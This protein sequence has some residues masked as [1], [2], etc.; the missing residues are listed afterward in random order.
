MALRSD[1]HRNRPIADLAFDAGTTTG[2]R[3]ATIHVSQEADAL[4][5]QAGYTTAADAMSSFPQRPF[6]GQLDPGA[7]DASQAHVARRAFDL[8]HLDGV[9]CADRAPLVYFK[10]VSR[11]DNLEIAALH[12]TFW[13]HGGAPI[14]VVRRYRC[15]WGYVTDTWTRPWRR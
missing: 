10:W 2:P 6:P 4:H 11:I 15:Q 1:R 14:L 9:L 7:H 12:R 3:C 8:L 5:E 13:N